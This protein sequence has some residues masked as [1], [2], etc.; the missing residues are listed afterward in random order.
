M[1]KRIDLS[2]QKANDM[3]DNSTYQDVK[4]MMDN[5]YTSQFN[6]DIPEAAKILNISPQFLYREAKIGKVKSIK[7]GGRI[8]IPRTEIINILIHGV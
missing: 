6:F 8:L 4:N 2:M 7:M 5:L 3:A 1:N